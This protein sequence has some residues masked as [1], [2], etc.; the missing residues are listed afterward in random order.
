MMRTSFL[1]VCV[2]GGILAVACSSSRDNTFD[3][4]SSSGGGGSSGGTFGNGDDDGAGGKPC[5]PDPGNYDI[6]DNG[7]DDDGDGKVDNPPTCDDGLDVT[8]DAEDFARAMGICTKASAKGYGLVSATFTRGFNRNEAPQ[9]EQ[10]GILPKFGN[11]IKPREGGSLGVLS[12]G[13]AREYNGAANAPFGG[14]GGTRNNPRFNG[15]D[16]YNYGR[17]VPGRP[18]N[19]T[20][21]PGFPKA[22]SGCQQESA[23][24]DVISLKLELKAPRNVS[25]IRFDFN[26]YSGEWPAYICSP[27]NDGFIAYLTAKGFNS[28]VGDNMS[29]DKDNNPVSVNNGFFDRCTPNF[30]TGCAPDSER[31]ATSACPGGV[32]E[33]GGTGFGIDGAWCSVYD[34]GSS[35][36]SVNGGAT[37][38][39]TSQAPVEAGETFTLE[40]MIWDTGD[41]LLDSSVLV[42]N[43]AWAEG[44]VSTSTDRPPK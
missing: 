1:S 34:G 32:A 22:A 37:G 29:F 21:P 6:P 13:H 41:A 11:V 19:G 4:G 43:F 26:F 36:R 5:V 35:A 16:W 17:A 28:G 3:D 30:Q 40:L 24:N 8:G 2:L 20:A 31:T 14:V 18:G 12:T 25:G 39:L 42:D 23:V 7:C 10:H 27:F 9:A 15:K 38:W 44:A 33:L